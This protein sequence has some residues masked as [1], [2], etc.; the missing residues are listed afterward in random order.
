M[1][2][3][4]KAKIHRRENTKELNRQESDMTQLYIHKVTREVETGG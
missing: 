2:A 3:K 4:R 1:K